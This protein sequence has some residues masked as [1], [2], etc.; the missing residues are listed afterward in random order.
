MPSVVAFAQDLISRF[1]RLKTKEFK[2]ADFVNSLKVLKALWYIR[3]NLAMFQ[4]ANFTIF[5][6]QVTSAQDLTLNDLQNEVTESHFV[7]QRLDNN[8]LKSLT[9]RSKHNTH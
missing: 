2:S 1:E 5:D 6:S 7:H 8:F 4:S 9:D 3:E